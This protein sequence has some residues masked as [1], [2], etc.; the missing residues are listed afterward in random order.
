MEYKYSS[1]NKSNTLTQ[2][3]E[4]LANP[5]SRSGKDDERTLTAAQLF[6]QRQKEHQDH[7][8]SEIERLESERVRCDAQVLKLKQEYEL[9]N[10]QL[11]FLRQFL[12]EAIKVAFPD[13]ALTMLI[14][15]KPP[16]LHQTIKQ[17]K[18]F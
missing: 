5:K 15:N 16:Q 18:A 8:E 12:E 10:Q 11:I 2:R 17:E 14:P 4:N 3:K 1:S 13:P 9:V 7:L 6:R